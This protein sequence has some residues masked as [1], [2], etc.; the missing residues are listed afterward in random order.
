MKTNYDTN[1]FIMVKKQIKK[2]KRKRK[3]VSTKS[4]QNYKF[5]TSEKSKN[6]VNGQT[7]LSTCNLFGYKNKIK[8]SEDCL[9]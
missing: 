1:P 9:T 8:I 5:N 3:K 6:K 4:Y 7:I 2:I